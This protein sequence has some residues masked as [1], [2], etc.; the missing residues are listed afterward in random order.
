MLGS[1]TVI[2]KDGQRYAAN[3]LQVLRKS[4]PEYG[5]SV[6]VFECSGVLTQ[7]DVQDVDRIELYAFDPVPEV[8]YTAGSAT[9]A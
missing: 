1:L 2:R 4:W 9:P 8:T 5:Q 7:F 6:L 3:N